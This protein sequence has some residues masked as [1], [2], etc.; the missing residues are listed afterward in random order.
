MDQAAK[1]LAPGS[2][3]NVVGDDGQIFGTDIFNS[4]SL[5]GARLLDRAA[6]AIIGTGFFVRQL[7]TCPP[8]S[9]CALH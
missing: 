4:R 2:I 5:I 8:R 7:E 1:S 9:R 6:D 3:V